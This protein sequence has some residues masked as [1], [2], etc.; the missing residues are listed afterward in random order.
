M[1][2]G[3]VPVPAHTFPALKHPNLAPFAFTVNL[4]RHV[5]PASHEAVV[6]ALAPFKAGINRKG[7]RE[8]K[9]RRKEG[10]DKQQAKHACC[11]PFRSSVIVVVLC[12]LGV[13]CG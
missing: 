8:R 1:G 12:A 4:K 3:L 5:A 11:S 13:L 6:L 10:D 2:R 9:G 7:R